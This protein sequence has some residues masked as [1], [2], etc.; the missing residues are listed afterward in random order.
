[1]AVT[2]LQEVIGY[3]AAGTDMQQVAVDAPRGAYSARSLINARPRLIAC[4]AK[5]IAAIALTAGR[6]NE[7]KCGIIIR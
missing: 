4:N 7:Y 6:L 1:M 3:N 2:A 5:F